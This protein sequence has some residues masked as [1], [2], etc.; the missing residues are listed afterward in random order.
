MA[1]SLSLTAADQDLRAQFAGMR[2]RRDLAD[3]LEVDYR[4]LV[5]HLYASRRDSQY[6]SFSI[7]KKSGGVRTISAPV[8]SLKIIQR[9]LNQVF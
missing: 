9:K 7:P 4:R 1:S 8:P 6:E 3:L 5:Y 2:T